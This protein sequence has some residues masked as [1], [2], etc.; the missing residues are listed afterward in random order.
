MSLMNPIVQNNNDDRYNYYNG[1]HNSTDTEIDLYSV[2][3][4][5]NIY[6][7]NKTNNKFIIFINKYIL[8]C[9]CKKIENLNH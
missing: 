9:F 7:N 3:Y 4:K 8:C 6:V 2:Y 5:Q 1:S